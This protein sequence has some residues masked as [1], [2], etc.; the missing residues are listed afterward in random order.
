MIYVLA[1]WQIIEVFLLVGHLIPRSD[2][3]YA[4]RYISAYF[5]DIEDSLQPFFL[6]V[7]TPVLFFFSFEVLLLLG[8][9]VLPV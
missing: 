8:Q 1:S 6:L 5:Q 9:T 7:L 3:D 2:A 4:L